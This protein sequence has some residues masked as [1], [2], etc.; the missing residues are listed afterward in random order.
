MAQTEQDP[1]R[2][3]KRKKR[4]R[5]K[6]ALPNALTTR[7]EFLLKSA[8][9]AGGLAA[10][11]VAPS[12]KTLNV[13]VAYA[14]ITGPPDNGGGTAPMISFRASLSGAHPSV[15]NTIIFDDEKHDDGG[16]YNPTTGEF[17]APS[18]GV[19]TFAWFLN[20]T[21]SGGGFPDVQ[22][23]INGSIEAFIRGSGRLN[24]TSITLK[25]AASEVVSLSSSVPISGGDRA[26]FSGFQN[27]R[28]QARPPR[29]RI[30]KRVRVSSRHA[31][32]LHGVG[33]VLRPGFKR[34]PEYWDFLTGTT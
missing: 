23:R 26:M 2:G 34:E 27:Y 13:P 32:V 16:N 7:R 14:A 28:S 1:A 24:S 19:Y 8:G 3:K 30:C 25:L 22:L 15:G 10:F 11:Y 9:A 6:I 5:K 31:G 17:T 12:F 33:H 29:F 4:S 20:M 21:G 18:S